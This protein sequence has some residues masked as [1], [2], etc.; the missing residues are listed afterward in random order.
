M[1]DITAYTLRSMRSHP[2]TRYTIM[3]AKAIMPNMATKNKS[4]S[5]DIMLLF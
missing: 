2:V 3:Q 5:L 1:A 4:M